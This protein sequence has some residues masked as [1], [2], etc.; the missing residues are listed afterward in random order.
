VKTFA[1]NFDYNRLWRGTEHDRTTAV[2]KQA[3]AFL[4]KGDVKKAWLLLLS[5]TKKI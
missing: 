5:I 3:Q 1:E 2:H 4:V